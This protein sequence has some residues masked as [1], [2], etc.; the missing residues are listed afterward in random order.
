MYSTGKLSEIS[1]VSSRTLRYYDEIGLL[2]PSFINESGYRY[3]DDKEV[4][5][6]QQIL[7]YKKRGFD[8]HTIKEIIY[9]KDFDLSSALEEHLVSLEEEKKKIDSMI[10]S[11]KLSIKSLKGEYNMS[12][13]EKFEV[14]KKNLIDENERTY[15]KEI[16]EKYG[17]D[18]IDESNRK[19]LNMN[20]EDY[21]IFKEL[22]ENIL[23]LVEKCVKENLDLDSKEAKELA[24]MHQKWLKMTWNKYSVEAHKSLAMMYTMDERFKEYYDRNIEGCADY[25]SMAIENNL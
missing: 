24:N 13:K 5:L 15:G 16:R 1:G 21:K 2:K 19:M 18:S 12:D 8:L 17:D 11:V 3:Y 20:E 25:L 4:A 7:F 14:F 10:N 22:E 9:R 23:T 6:L